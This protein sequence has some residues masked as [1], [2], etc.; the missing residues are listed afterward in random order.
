M[1]RALEDV[2]EITHNLRPYHL[3]Q[4][5]LR[6]ALEFMIERI[7]SSSG[8]RFAAQ[9]DAVH[10]IFSKEAEMNLYRI[11]Q[12]GINNI[13]KHSGATEAKVAL[14]CHG[15]LVKLMIED[16]GRGFISNTGGS[17]EAHPPGYGL[18]GI[19]ERVRI[20]GGK[21]VIHSAPGHGTTITIT[22]VLQDGR[23]AD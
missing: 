5:G 10:E 7:A 2:R 21:Q 22:V 12:E 15:R 17:V 6:D 1:S 19:A 23:H 9:I 8:I 20:L 16:N 3:D 4:L 18:T 11:V 13:V 14:K